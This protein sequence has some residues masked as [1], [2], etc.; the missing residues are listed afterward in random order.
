MSKAF[1][2]LEIL[3]AN[4]QRQ[5]APDSEVFHDVK[6]DGIHSK[7]KRQIDVLV[8]QNIGQYEISIIID[9]KDYSRPIDVKGVE[10]FDGLLK[11]VG[12]QKGVLVCPKGFTSTAKTRAKGLQIDLYS[13]VDTDPNTWEIDPT[14]PALCDYRTAGM[15]F[16]LSTSAPL[17]FTMPNDFY[18]T[19]I[20]YDE[21]NNELGTMLEKSM[22]NWNVGIYPGEPGEHLDLL[23][24]DT[25]EVITD[26]GYG[27]KIPVNVSVSLNVER[28]LYF[29]QF[30]ILN[31]SNYKNEL[32]GGTIANVFTVDILTSDEVE[33]NW[34]KIN[35]EEQAPITPVISL[36]GRV[37]W[38]DE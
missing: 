24:F 29:G 4:I 36:V 30:P 7:R 33:Q 16:S 19:N 34:Q 25:S 21:L 14:I 12:A 35:T 17:P 18:A 32:S 5:L 37:G 20:I 1:R 10:Q 23:I 31:I 13:I 11:D 38:V 6:L 3:I 27:M 9:C 8:K 28:K 2:E 26:N 15:A 22:S